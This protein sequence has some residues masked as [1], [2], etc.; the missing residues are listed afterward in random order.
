MTTR[1][2]V[3]AV[4]AIV[5]AYL[6]ALGESAVSRMSRHHAGELAETGRRGS[7]A[8]VKVASDPAGYVSTTT[9]LRVAAES[10]AA[11]LVTIAVTEHVD[12]LWRPLAISAAIMLVVSFTLVGVS[13]RT[14]GVQHSEAVSLLVAP[15]M[16]WLRRILGPVARLLVALGNAFT[17]GKGYV[18]GPF[19]TEAELR[20]L[21]DMAEES[22]VI[23]DDEREMIH[24]VFELGDT[25]AR[26]VMVPRTDMITLDQDKPLRK[27]M[28]LFLRSGFSRIPVIG[29]DNDDV[30][31]LLYL[32]DVARWLLDDPEDQAL[33]VQRCM[34]PIHFVPD[35]KPIDDL[36]R[37][38]Q[39]DQT[40]LAIVV[41]EYGGTA[42]LITM[43]DIVEEIV[44][45]I[46]DEYDKESQGVEELGE[47]RYRIP[48]T[49]HVDDFADEFDLDLDEEDVDTVGGLLA[50]A[51]G[52]V[53]IVGSTA[54]VLGHRLTAERPAGRRHRIATIIV[55]RVAEAEPV[56]EDEQ[57][58]Q[59]AL[60]RRDRAREEHRERRREDDS[61][62]AGGATASRELDH[63][64]DDRELDHDT[65]D[66]TDAE[67]VAVRTG[68]DD[69]EDR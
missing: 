27:G 23:E 35:S 59:D 14:L 34:R 49:L 20:D 12:G 37:E 43:E 31:G 42:G 29:E 8:L 9:F 15:G 58:L 28:S 69:Q 54:E 67:R 53:P 19:E 44:G 38:M 36:L 16:V 51:L 52:R 30:V 61:A 21:V 48:A 13:P 33:P 6:L 66:R 40:H 55:E 2:I 60:R 7:A 11:V 17:P 56:D 46:D 3:G 64:T 25:L 32:K 26:E 24:S 18:D 39:Q 5:V 45:E 41:D 68:Q 65:D 22:D 1:L 4:L 50:K 63:D 62:S 47:D 10:L 57:L